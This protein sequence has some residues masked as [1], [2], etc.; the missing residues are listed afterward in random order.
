MTERILGSLILVFIACLFAL[1]FN[2]RAVFGQDFP[3]CTEFG[4]QIPVTCCCS[5]S[6]CV[7]APATEFENIGNDNYRSTVTGQIVKRTGWS[8]GGFVKCACDLIDGKWTKH[9]KA[10]IRCLFAPMPSS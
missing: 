8:A 5:N 1:W 10:N 9:P 6:C 4:V 2:V 3:N 7:E